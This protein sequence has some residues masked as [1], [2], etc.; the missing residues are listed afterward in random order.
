MK[1]FDKLSE[2]IAWSKCYLHCSY[3]DCI[4]ICV[5]NK[6]ILYKGKR[7][8]AEKLINGHKGM[9]CLVTEEDVTFHK[10]SEPFEY[11]VCLN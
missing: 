10:N 4:V 11:G 6:N 7:S 3:F 8:I 1:E 5:K 2:A 9:Y